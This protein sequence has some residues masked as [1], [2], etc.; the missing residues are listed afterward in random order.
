MARPQSSP[1]GAPGWLALSVFLA[2][3]LVFA[4]LVFFWIGAAL[5]LAIVAL[6]ALPALLVVG[7]IQ[8]WLGG[9]AR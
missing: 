3:W 8:M 2:A 4:V 9:R 7:V 5:T 6:L 1:A